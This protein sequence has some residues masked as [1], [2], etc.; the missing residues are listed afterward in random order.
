MIEIELPISM[1]RAF[2]TSLIG[3]IASG[4]GARRVEIMQLEDDTFG[5]PPQVTFG[6]REQRGHADTNVTLMFV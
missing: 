2:S 3:R 6:K 1:N 4:T 5:G